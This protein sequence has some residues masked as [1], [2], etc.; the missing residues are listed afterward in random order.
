VITYS[1]AIA[2]PGARE[3]IRILPPDIRIVLDRSGVIREV[4]A[5]EEI[6]TTDLETWI[7]MPW[8]DTVAPMQ[9]SA[10]SSIL[11]NVKAGRN[12]VSCEID[13]QFP[14]GRELPIEYTAILADHDESIVAIGKNNQAI[15]ELETKLREAQH[16]IANDHIRMREAES[17]YQLLLEASN[18]AV[19]T[20]DS[21]GTGVLEANVVA[22]RAFGLERQSRGKSR[23]FDFMEILP[24][25][26]RQAL[27]AMLEVVRESTTAPGILLHFGPNHTPWFARA[28]LTS[29]E[30][31]TVF[32]LRLS[33]AERPLAHT[34]AQPG[35]ETR[36]ASN[37]TALLDH[38]PH[39]FAIVDTAG[40]IEYANDAFL[41]LVQ[42]GSQPLVRGRNLNE[43]MS[44]PGA[45]FRTVMKTLES[46]R[47]LRA[48]PTALHGELGLE[49][50]VEVAAAFLSE[51]GETR[52]GVMLTDVSRRIAPA[53]E[54]L[55][56][57]VALMSG[58]LGKRT[59]R[60]VTREAVAMI[61]RQYLESAL[62]AADDNRTAA[63]ESLGLSRQ[64]LYAK[65]SRYGLLEDESDGRG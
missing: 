40:R 63:A 48:F 42:V 59:L 32:L 9:Q 11:D 54:K 60:Q 13:Q 65:L 7:G 45:D 28:A 61:E 22:L 64:S 41:D 1:M 50:E 49:T 21:S 62:Q 43:W 35:M 58:S 51:S 14:D 19:L 2:S 24:A 44:L 46:N 17:R 3:R 52:I 8:S 47:A 55:D 30:L 56:D 27:R 10:I 16:E 25:N 26:D 53:G 37:V 23:K 18:D 12:G 15:R 38:W 33:P 4:A 39:S 5:S 6:A 57:I 36:V 34:A 29:A 31:R 20:L